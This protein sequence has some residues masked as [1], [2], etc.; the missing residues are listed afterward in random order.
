VGISTAWEEADAATV[1]AIELY[2]RDDP[3]LVG[4]AGAQGSGKSTMALRLVDQLR[5]RGLRTAIL[6]L[7]DFYLTRTEREQLGRSVHPLLVTRGVPGTHDLALL[8]GAVDALLAGQG[9]TVP[10]FDKATDDR[11]ADGR[12]VDGPVD[13]VLLEG[14][15]IGARPQPAAALV[16]PVNDLE[17]Y[18]DDRGTWRRWING[19]LATDYGSLFDRLALRILM[20]A[21]GFDVV[22]RWRTQQERSLPIGGMDA[23]ALRRFIDHY[24]RITRWMLEDEPADLVID[25]DQDRNPALRA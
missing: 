8:S 10:R 25:L 9:V 20:R 23:A 6:S 1:R 16:D 19:R 7:D 13:V 15:C 14:W 21:P 12:R 5:E 18:E 11:A 3:V 4:L 24:E 2:H 22:L 17:R